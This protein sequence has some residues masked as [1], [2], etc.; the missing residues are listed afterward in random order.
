MGGMTGTWAGAATH[1]WEINALAT[2]GGTAGNAL[3][4]DLMEYTGMLTVTANSGNPFIINL[5]SLDMLDMP[6]DLANFDSGTAYSWL[7]A[8]AGN[9]A[10]SDLT[11]YMIDATDFQNSLGGGAFS[12]SSVAGDR[13]LY[14]NFTPFSAA[15][16]VPQ[17]SSLWLMLVVCAAL[18]VLLGKNRGRARWFTG[19]PAASG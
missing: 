16:S 3:G 1:I 7:I 18:L 5:N 14:L 11:A 17:P 9:A 4:W 13:E 2:D 6:G 10:F 8:S 19:N 15:A 12:V